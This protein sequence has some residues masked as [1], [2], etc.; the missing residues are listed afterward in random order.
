MSNP[1]V[2][3]LDEM[4]VLLERKNHD[5]ASD[6]NPFSNFEHA[7]AVSGLTVEQVFLAIIGIKIARLIE[8]VGSG[9][10]PNNEAIQDTRVDLANYATL[11]AAYHRE[12]G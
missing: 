11:N 1:I 8:L 6:S 4:R 3:M 9:K 2:S 5:Y 12:R 10:T 7:A